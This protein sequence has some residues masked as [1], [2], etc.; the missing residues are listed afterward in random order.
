LSASFNPTLN[1]NPINYPQQAG[2]FGRIKSDYMLLQIGFTWAYEITD[3]LSVGVEPT[4]NYGTLQLMPNPTANPSAAGYP[5]T[6]KATT[7][8]FGAQ[9]GL[10]FDSKK[11]FKAGLSY[12]S[13]QNLSEL[14]FKN[15]YLDN[16]KGT[17]K[18]DMDYPAVLSFGL[19]YSK[20]DF[21]VALDYRMVDYK[22]TNGF[23][24]T[25]WTPTASVKGFGW[26]NVSILSAG[27]QYKG[28]EKLPL[29]LG[30]TYSSNPIG[31][32]VAFFNIPATAIIKN[33]F[34][35]GFSYAASSNI[36]LDAV[37]HHGSSDGKTSGQMLNPMMASSSNPYGA[38]PGTT[39][40]YEMT[41]DLV[42]FG[43]SYKFD[44]KQAKL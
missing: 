10:Y 33:A 8:G 18:F 16:S 17:N 23:S 14:E 32:D 30:Y 20:S 43:I 37:Y 1:S 27:I 4:F 12:K 9:L 7:S 28:I 13:T 40:A 15:T 44:K 41:T 19:G 5:S 36:S 24:E 35:F 11:G 2:G 34:Q 29:R 25:G 3:K 31:S 26:D 39:V 42:M 38:V 6:D 21:D 22:N